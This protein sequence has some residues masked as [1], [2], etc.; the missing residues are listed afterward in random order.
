MSVFVHDSFV[1]RWSLVMDFEINEK[2][3]VVAENQQVSGNLPDGNVVI[4]NLNNGVYYGLNSVG[5]RVW[6]LVQQPISTMV[7]RDTLLAEFDVDPIRCSRELQ[8][9]LSQMTAQGMIQVRI[10]SPQGSVQVK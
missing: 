8:Q 7:L 5:G 3:I 2:T 6:S 10:N 4:L 9:L 1:A